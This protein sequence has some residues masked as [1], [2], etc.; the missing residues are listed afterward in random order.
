MVE[1]FSCDGLPG[2]TTYTLEVQVAA[3]D[4][5]SDGKDGD[6]DYE[7]DGEATTLSVTRY[8]T[9]VG[10][11]VYTRP[12]D[13]GAATVLTGSGRDGLLDGD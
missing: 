2:T 3:A 13:G 7:D 6:G 10:V 9:A 12:A 5:A 1:A 4:D 8:Y 11:A